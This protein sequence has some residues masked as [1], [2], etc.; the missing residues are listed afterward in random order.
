MPWGQRPQEAAPKG[1]KG[2]FDTVLNNLRTYNS[3]DH[4]SRDIWDQLW[5]KHGDITP[6][7]SFSKHEKMDTKSIYFQKHCVKS[8]IKFHAGLFKHFPR[9]YQGKAVFQA[10][11]FHFTV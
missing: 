7:Y 9:G 8:H 11:C 2:P 3:M 1:P 10:A 5:D 4:S 6:F